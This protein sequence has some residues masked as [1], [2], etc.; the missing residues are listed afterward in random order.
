[1]S[2]DLAVTRACALATGQQPIW[3]SNGAK[4]MPP[5]YLAVLTLR[6]LLCRIPK[7]AN[8]L[9]LRLC[10]EVGIFQS[11]PV[12]GQALCGLTMPKVKTRRRQPLTSS[13][14]PA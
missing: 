2:L 9:E 1:M 7:G 10:P 8:L 12:V 11:Q 3:Q 13:A 5:R 6:H 14:Q 4:L